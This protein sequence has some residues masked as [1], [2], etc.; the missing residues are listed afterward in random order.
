MYDTSYKRLLP[1]LL[2]VI[3]LGLSIGCDRY[4]DSKDP[5]RSLP[6][7]PPV[8]SGLGVRWNDRTVTLG[9]NI[10]DPSAVA[11]YRVYG[12]AQ[13]NRDYDLI[14]T[15]SETSF[16]VSG[17]PF[18]EEV[19]L[20]VAAVTPSG[21][22]GE[23]SNPISVVAGLLSMRIADG[24]AFT[25]RR[26]IQIYFTVP[27]PAAYVELSE[28]PDFDGVSPREFSSVM[29][30]DLSD[31]D[32]TKTVYAR[33]TFEDGS[34]AGED[35]SDDIILDRSAFIDSVYFA[36]TGTS[37]E[38]GDTITFFI[39]ADGEAEGSAGVTFP[40]TNGVSLYD[41]GTNGDLTAGDG[42]YSA[43]Y[44]VPVGLVVVDQEVTGSFMDAAGNRAVNVLS[45]RLLNILTA[46]PPTP[47]TLAVGL[48]DSTTA[49]LSWTPNSESDFASYRVYRSVSPGISVENDFLTVSIITNRAMVS[50]DDF[51][52][53]TGAYY[54]R[55]FVF[56]TQDL[57]AGS[58]E[59]AVTR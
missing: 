1:I 21:L 11:W 17:L 53:G 3:V 36:P 24:E 39:S 37:F 43:R 15:T 6:A 41:V 31:G 14:D 18:D 20:R 50:H 5:V 56:N 58:N 49:H 52:S 54:Y 59:V 34:V 13:P 32:G 42:V 47:V 38:V 7:A 30:F 2:A 10:G 8:P 9:W 27:A 12:S 33:L 51:L 26:E 57:S 28:D 4:I 55:V 40:G 29:S 19:W 46:E 22:E 25:S 16:I 48:I 44:V 35:I 23:P 45:T